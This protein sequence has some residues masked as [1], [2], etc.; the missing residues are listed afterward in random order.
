MAADQCSGGASYPLGTLR[1]PSLRSAGS[2]ERKVTE[3]LQSGDHDWSGARGRL[4]YLIGGTWRAFAAFAMR[5]AELPLSDPHGF[6]LAAKHAERLAREISRKRPSDLAQLREISM[7]RAEKLPDASA[8]LRVLLSVLEPEALV[9]SSW[10]LREGLHFQG[11]DQRERARDPLLAGVEAFATGRAAS[12]VDAEAIVR[13]AE[14]IVEAGG[15]RTA[16]L[17]LA[18]AQLAIALHRV[19]PNLRAPHALEWSLD[20]RW[21]GLDFRGRAMLGAAL[22][23]SLGLTDPH[24]RLLPMAGRDDLREA[25]AWGLA[26]RLAQRFSAGSAEVLAAARLSCDK[27]RLDLAVVKSHAALVSPSVAKDFNTLAR[28]LGLSPRLNVAD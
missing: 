21:I 15:E 3:M 18:A 28:W 19:E 16:T 22:R 2:F 20:K 8:L 14:G 13:W 25:T 4:L 27:S 10:G 11:L 12:L 9:F 17:R 6:I 24:A 23:A 7:L 1:L 5:S 26:I